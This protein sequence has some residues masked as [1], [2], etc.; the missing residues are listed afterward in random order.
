H[1]RDVAQVMAECYRTL[2]P[3]GVLL[4]AFPQF[5]QPAES[6]LGMVT[7]APALQWFFSGRA[8]TAAYHDIT[9]ER[10]EAAHWYARETPELEPWERMRSLNGISVRRFRQIVRSNPGWRMEYW[11]TRPIFS[12]R[13]ER[14]GAYRALSALFGTFARTPLLE[15][16]FLGRIACV[17]RRAT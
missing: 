15:E 6:H 7:R 3:G 2:K 11:S 1:V 9:K 16:L 12:G 14:G 5:L 10:G 13:G 8:L 17:L 4:T